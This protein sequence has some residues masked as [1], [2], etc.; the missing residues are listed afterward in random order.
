MSTKVKAS[1]FIEREQLAKLKAISERTMIP[2]SALMRRAINS[3]I[4]E[5]KK[6]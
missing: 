1:I 6:K 3:V 4:E 2:M 5:Y